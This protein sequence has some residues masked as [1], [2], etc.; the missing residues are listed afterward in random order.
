[1]NTIRLMAGMGVLAVVAL[2]VWAVAAAV[3]SARHT[4]HDERRKHQAGPTCAPWPYTH[5][6]VVLPP[7][8][9]GIPPPPPPSPR[10][11]AAL[12]AEAAERT[13]R[14]MVDLAQ[15]RAR[16]I[17]DRATEAATAMVTEAA[18]TSRAMVAEAQQ[19]A[20]EITA[21]AEER[22]HERERP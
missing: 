12:V 20:Y 3:G 15:E 11:P 17:V 18:E 21:L 4:R 22:A 1:V 2:G 8:S 13:A 6:I 14:A 10:D 7:I 16:E 5:R 9:T 19:R